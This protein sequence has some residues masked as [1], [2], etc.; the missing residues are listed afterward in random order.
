VTATGGWTRVVAVL[1]ARTPGGREIVVADG[2]VPTGSGTRR[3]TIR[4]ADVAVTIPARSRLRLTI[5]ASSVVQDPANLVYL[6]P[7]LPGAARL[8]VGDAAVSVPV[9]RDTS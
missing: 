5:G 4:L 9:L 3:V 1:S 2:A 8:A 6:Q 7:A